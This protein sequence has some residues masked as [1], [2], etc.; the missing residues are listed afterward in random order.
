MLSS[1]QRKG[2][3]VLLILIQY[4]YTPEPHRHF[5]PRRVRGN[6]E[7]VS[8]LIACCSVT[9]PRVRLYGYIGKLGDYW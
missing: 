9:I 6:S 3:L 5:V 7:S 4:R 8:L 2:Y 1:S